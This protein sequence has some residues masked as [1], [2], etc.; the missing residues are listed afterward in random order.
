M[1]GFPARGIDLLILAALLA[2]LGGLTVQAVEQR[3]QVLASG[4]RAPFCPP[5]EVPAFAAGFAAL[6]ELLGERMGRPLECE[7]PDP[8]SGDLLQKTT[9]GLAVYRWC[10]NTPTFA[11]G[12]DHWA[13]TPAGPL[14]WSGP[15]VD[16]PVPLQSVQPSSLR[17]PCPPGP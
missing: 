17:R 14:R 1:P 5:G 10:T 11:A 12:A 9:T 3:E 13:L 15:S 6:S 2:V 16:P 8:A 7:H 4:Q